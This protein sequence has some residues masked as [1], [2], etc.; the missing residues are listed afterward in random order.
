MKPQSA[1]AK[2]RMLQ[3]AVA[4]AIRETFP[5]LTEDD[6]RSTS[7][8][9]NGADV[10]LSTRARNAF[11]YSIECKAVEKLNM[12]SAWDQCKGNTAGEDTPLLVCRKNR[13]E[14]LAILP[15]TKLMQLSSPGEE[16]EAR[17]K[18][19]GLLEDAV[20]TLDSM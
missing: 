2:G 3:Q 10:Q 18:L 7:M 17:A 6:V 13:S 5:G 15:L 19:R 4:A 9:A 11:P 14:T 20:K 8:G 12:W 16:K 1:K